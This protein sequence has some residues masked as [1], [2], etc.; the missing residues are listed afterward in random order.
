MKKSTAA[1]IFV[2]MMTV[3]MTGIAQSVPGTP[4]A[5]VRLV[6]RSGDVL[7]AFDFSD[8]VSFLRVRDALRERLA[9]DGELSSVHIHSGASPDGNTD[10]NQALSDSRAEDMH[11]FLLHAMPELERVPFVITSAGED[12]ETLRSLLETSDISGADR[13]AEIIRTVPLWITDASGDVVDG[14]KK[15]LMDLQ[16]GQTWL[17]MRETLFPL[18]RRTQVEFVVEGD[19]PITSA[20]DGA[21]SA[22]DIKLFFPLGDATIRPNYRNNAEAL[23]QLRDL[24]ENR[25]YMAGDIIRVVGKAS[26]DGAER[27]NNALARRRAEAIRKYIATH[28]PG[29]AD[30]VSVTV[31]GEAWEDFRVAVQADTQLSEADGRSIQDIIAS[32]KSADAKEAALRRLPAWRNYSRSLF[33]DLRAAAI[34]P[35]FVSERFRIRDSEL[36]LPELSWDLAAPAFEMRPDKLTVPALTQRSRRIIRPVIGLSTNLIYDITYIP[37]YG[38]T[39][40]PSITLEYY[41]A[42]SRHFTFGF[43]VEFPMWQ[44]WDTHRFLQVN[45]LTLWARRYF[46]ER[47]DRFRGLYLLGS[48]NGAR[49]GV[50]W[51]AKG[52]EGEG[53]GASVGVG[54]KWLLGRSR[55]FIDLGIALGAFYSQYDPYV[56]G[57]DP[58]RRYYYDYV[59]DPKFFRER[60]HRWFWFGPTRAYISLGIDLF[61]RKRR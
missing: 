22:N 18:L 2:V 54:H 48:V 16:G 1:L 4:D 28:W 46:R 49:F 58:T 50:G 29:F 36:L 57:N 31:E 21:K 61:N 41:P 10:A 33:P 37:G 12:Y 14:R 9:T 52:W 25:G 15:Q 17:A 47:E 40:A 44:H 32:T 60:N 23:A 45:N 6:S 53:V 27:V 51:D 26:L 13:A 7:Q 59:G 56:F 19:S 5:I 11:T 42:R 30:V 24:L 38:L 3:S 8:S 35:D 34:A 43:D 20:N 39:S 55:F